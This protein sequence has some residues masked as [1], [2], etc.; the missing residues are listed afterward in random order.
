MDER[1]NTGS[2]L[3]GRDLPGKERLGSVARP[4]GW[5]GLHHG[6]Y[7]PV[8]PTS[9]RIWNWKTHSAL[10]RCVRRADLS[11]VLVV[12]SLRLPAGLF[13][14]LVSHL[15]KLVGYGQSKCS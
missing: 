4:T 9:P 2:A 11:I 6:R 8:V 1:S 13:D 15:Q 14:D 5:D 3:D 10:A 12:Y 7:W